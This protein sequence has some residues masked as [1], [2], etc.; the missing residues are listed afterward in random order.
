MWDYTAVTGASGGAA[1][2]NGVG[3]SYS[4]N[5]MPT[6]PLTNYGIIPNAFKI[7]SQPIA[8]KNALYRGYANG[9][10]PVRSYGIPITYNL[11]ITSGDC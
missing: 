4:A 10:T 2:Q 7:L 9:A 5:P 11:S 6:I 1:N 8:N 3:N